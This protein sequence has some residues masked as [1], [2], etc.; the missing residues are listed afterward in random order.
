MYKNVKKVVGAWTHGTTN[1][2]DLPASDGNS[3]TS[4]FAFEKWG[5]GKKFNAVQFHWHAGSEHTVDGMRMDMEIHTVHVA[6]EEKEKFK[7]AALGV[8]FDRKNYYNSRS[9]Y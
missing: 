5:A 7:Y 9:E 3:F 4:E 8:M 6:E 2:W 1:K